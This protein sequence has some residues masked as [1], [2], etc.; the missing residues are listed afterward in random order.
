MR[1]VLQKLI[2]ISALLL[3]TIAPA[4]AQGRPDL[5][6]WAD[7][8]RAPA[9][10]MLLRQ[11]SEDY[12][13]RA[14]VQQIGMGDIRSNLTIAGP[15]G[16]GPDIVI[17][18]HDWLGEYLQNG[19]IVPIDL[20]DKAADFS[21]GALALFT[22]DGQLYGMPYA[23][24]NLAFFRNT[25]LVPEAPA[26][27]D[28]VFTISQQIVSSGAARYGWVFTENGSYDFFPVMSAFG[29][30]VFGRNAD[31]SYNP[32]DVGIGSAG[33]IAAGEYVRQYLDAGL[34]APGINN[35][36]A[37]S[38]FTTGDAAMV[39]TGPW[40]LNRVRDSGIPFDISNIPAGPAGEGR[41]FIGGQGFMI[42]A[43]S[44]NQL[45]AQVF[46]TEFM[47]TSEAMLAMY[48]VD[49]R[50]PAYIPALEQI[51][52]EAMGKFQRAGANGVPQ[53]AIPEM[54]SVWGSWGNALLFVV[55]GELTPAEAYTQAQMQIVTLIGALD[56]PPASVGLVG[57]VQIAFGCPGDWDPA[58]PNTQMTD[59]GGAIYTLSTDALAA[60]DYEVKIAFDGTWDRNYGVGGAAGGD[61]YRFTVGAAGSTITFTFDNSTK[62]LTIEGAG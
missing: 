27:W 20:G 22:A 50:P 45:L 35:D 21:P 52:D 15:A 47:A 19:A 8:T 41:P 54:A 13:V 11:F 44:Q 56:A 24:E 51:D 9:L 14:V 48:N 12:G 59:Q 31:G 16:E 17:G 34:Y 4:A 30:Y 5:L 10:E 42:S 57:T 62:L 61:N 29:G 6:I 38:L 3:L 33:T 49:P 60:G 2:V 28:E 40:F 7:G 46:L 55:N 32:A 26:T 43:F 36:V 18:A 1:P 25:D 23:V 58:C 39:L 53:P 37:V